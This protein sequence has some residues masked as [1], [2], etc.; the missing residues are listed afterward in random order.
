[1]LTKIYRLNAGRQM[2]P[3]KE[4]FLWEPS[5]MNLR[6]HRSLLIFYI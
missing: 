1:M 3:Q 4:F 2:K 5:D 6:K